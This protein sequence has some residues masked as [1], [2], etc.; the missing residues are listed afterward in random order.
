MVGWSCVRSFTFGWTMDSECLQGCFLH[1]DV[2]TLIKFCFLLGN[3]PWQSH[4]L[5]NEVLSTHAPL[6][7]TVCWWRNIIRYEQGNTKD[8]AC[9]GASATTP[10]E[11]H[12]EHV[13][14]MLMEDY[15]RI[16]T[17]ITVKSQKSNRHVCITLTCNLT[18]AAEVTLETLVKS[19]NS[20]VEISI[21]VSTAWG[22]GGGGGGKEK[23]KSVC[24]F[25]ITQTSI[26]D[27]Q[28]MLASCLV[29]L[30]TS[31]VDRCW[32]AL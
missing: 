19:C 11:R 6:C 1:T 22:K 29:C 26:F 15:S 30:A 18:S 8:A 27:L 5:L 13:H 14:A 21:C 23:K 25:T 12:A 3:T 7:E 32:T 2:C 16:W 10:D 31:D 20:S 28:R 24:V 9:K 17:L 4:D